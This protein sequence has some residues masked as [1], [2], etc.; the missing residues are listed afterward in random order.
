MFYQRVQRAWPQEFFFRLSCFVSSGSSFILKNLGTDGNNHE[1]WAW[2]L[3][4]LVGSQ[5][6]GVYP[7]H[8]RTGWMNGLF[9]FPPA[10]WDLHPSRG[11]RRWTFLHL[12]I[13]HTRRMQDH[14]RFE[15][16]VQF[17]FRTSLACQW[18]FTD[19]HNGITLRCHIDMFKCFYFQP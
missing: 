2:H 19:R 12:R 13:P 14:G 10:E 5:P 4:K 8:C 16:S 3:P 15:V 11:P 9:F 17:I 6:T 7:M 1:P 18:T